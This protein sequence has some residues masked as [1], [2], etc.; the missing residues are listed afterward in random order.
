MKSEQFRKAGLILATVLLMSGSYAQYHFSTDYFKIE[1]NSKG[2]ITGMKSISGKQ[3]REFA[4][5]GKASPLLCLYNN[6]KKLYYNPVS[7]SY[8]AGK[9]TFTIRFTNGSVAEISISSHAKYLKLQLKSLSPRNGIDDVQWGP[10]HTNISNLFGEVIGVARD[11]SDAV[12]YAIGILALNDITIG[13][14]SNLAGDAAPFQY[15][16]HSPDKKLYPLPSGLHEGQLFPIGGDGISD[17][18]FYAHPEPYY[19]ILYGNAAMVDST[20][21]ISL[22]YPARDRR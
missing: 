15:V 6:D 1:I 22:P 10:Y 19:R 13:G 7:A 2:C 11:T 9:K 17:V 18:A 21:N 20:G 16:I 5:H 14:T 3:S 4:R 12:N 8:D